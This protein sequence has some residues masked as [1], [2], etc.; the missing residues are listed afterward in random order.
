MGVGCSRRS[1]GVRRARFRRTGRGSR[2]RPADQMAQGSGSLGGLLLTAV[3]P[4][5]ELPGL[6]GLG[7][8]VGWQGVAGYVGVVRVVGAQGGGLNVLGAVCNGRD[9]VEPWAPPERFVLVRHGGL[10]PSPSCVVMQVYAR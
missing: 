7:R 10:L 2:C 9:A 3:R 8:R 6:G 1:W 5:G 4:G